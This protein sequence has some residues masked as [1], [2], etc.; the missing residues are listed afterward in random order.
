MEDTH[1]TTTLKHKF[2]RGASAFSVIIPIHGPKF[3]VGSAVIKLRNINK[4][5][6]IRSRGGRVPGTA[7]S[8]EGK[9]GAVT[10]KNKR[11]QEA[12]RIL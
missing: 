4:M 5:G 2:A 8:T 12:I 11:V 1:F 10:I 7:F 9:L 6:I 3:T